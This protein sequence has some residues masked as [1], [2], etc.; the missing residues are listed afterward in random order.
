MAKVQVVCTIGPKFGAF[1]EGIGSIVTVV[2]ALELHVP[3][4]TVNV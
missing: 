2:V 3:L 1:C 4:E